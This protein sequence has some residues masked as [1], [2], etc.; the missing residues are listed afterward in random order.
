MEKWYFQIERVHTILTWGILSYWTQVRVHLSTAIFLTFILWLDQDFV[1]NYLH[2]TTSTLIALLN[3]PISILVVASF[4]SIIG[5]LSLMIIL[6]A[7][8]LQQPYFYAC[9]LPL[10]F[11][12]IL[13]VHQSHLDTLLNDLFVLYCFLHICMHDLLCLST[14]N[15]VGV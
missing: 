15:T 4:P 3:H 1:G 8:I 5:I 7:E 12:W 13:F 14:L 9:A 11:S 2:K 10:P 6:T